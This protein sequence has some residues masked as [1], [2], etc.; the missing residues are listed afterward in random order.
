MKILVNAISAC[1]GGSVPYTSNLIDSF[2][3]RSVD[4]RFTVSARFPLP[5]RPSMVRL[6]ASDYRPAARLLWEQTLWRERVRQE[7]PDV[8]FSSA[9]FGLLTSPVPQL[10]LVREGGLFDPYYMSHCTP[11]QGVRSGLHRTLRRRLIIASARRAERVMTPTASMRTMLLNWAP[12]LENKVVVNAYGTVSGAFAPS[13]GRPRQWR[14]DGVTRL[15][16]VS[17]Y[18]PHKRP[19]MVARAAEALAA[20]GTA[21]HATITM[22]QRELGDFIGGAQDR[23]QL[24]RALASGHVTLGRRNYADLPALYRGH[25]VFVF[26]SVS[27]T[28]GRPMAEALSCGIPSVVADTP[29]NR[30]V[31]GDAALYFTP[32]SLTS[33]M[34][35]LDRLDADPDLRH[36]LTERGRRRVLGSYTWDQHVDRLIDILAELAKRGK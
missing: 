36:S 14:E 13:T 6:A 7:Q 21:A 27:E 35:C 26:P 11:E 30:E 16:Y 15:L 22:N 34:S 17:V 12:E 31:C 1:M 3:R 23:I 33:L 9:N 28:F 20:R 24:E 4:A 2:E 10:L 8:L 18:Y 25:D 5:D 19:G 29:I 32:D